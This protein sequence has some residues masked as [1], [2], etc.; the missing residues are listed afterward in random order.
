[1]SVGVMLSTLVPQFLYSCLNV[2]ATGCN[3]CTSLQGLVET[4]SHLIS[5]PV[6][7]EVPMFKQFQD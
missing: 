1:M 5:L 2:H 7:A 6:F 3:M 4:F